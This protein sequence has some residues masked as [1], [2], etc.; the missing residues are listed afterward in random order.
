MPEAYIPDDNIDM[1]D[2][3][4]DS[5]DDDAENFDQQIQKLL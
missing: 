5:D 2:G 4:P 3:T 1:Y